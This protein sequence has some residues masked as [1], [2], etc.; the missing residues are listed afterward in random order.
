MEVAT[1]TPIAKETV[2][3]ERADAQP[4][5]GHAYR[6]RR[7]D[8]STPTGAIEMA[9]GERRFGEMVER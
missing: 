6:G 9:S 3:G 2:A 8:S 4:M 7:I 1:H 5:R